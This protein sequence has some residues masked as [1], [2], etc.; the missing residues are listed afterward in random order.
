VKV[1][2]TEQSLG[3][4]F[5]VNLSTGIVT[6]TSAPSVSTKVY[7]G[8]QFNEEVRFESDETAVTL[9]MFNRGDVPSGL[10]VVSVFDGSIINDSYP[11]RG[12]STQTFSLGFQLTPQMGALVRLEP[13]ADDLQIELPSPVGWPLG[14]PYWKLVNVTAYTIDITVDGAVVAT[15]EASGDSQRRDVVEVWLG[16]NGSGDIEWSLIS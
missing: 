6:L 14:G 3:T 7:A 8:C 16:Y 9:E 12:A 5:T 15:I 10:R 11:Y 2:S 1:G 13:D 4:D